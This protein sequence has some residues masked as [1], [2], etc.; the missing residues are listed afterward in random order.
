[1]GDA[2]QQ[3]LWFCRKHPAVVLC[4]YA[5]IIEA[6]EPGVPEQQQDAAAQVAIP[7]PISCPIPK[8][9]YP[10]IDLGQQD[11]GVLFHLGPAALAVEKL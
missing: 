6:V 9:I 8:A 10:A 4:S 3:R 11:C 2:E 7:C 1:M 5:G